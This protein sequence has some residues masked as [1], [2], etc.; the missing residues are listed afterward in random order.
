[1]IART[2]SFSLTPSSFLIA[3]V[4]AKDTVDQATARRGPTV[5]AN[6]LVSRYVVLQGAGSIASVRGRD[7]REP[8]VQQ[9]VT[10]RA[11]A[12]RQQHATLRQAIEATGAIIVGDMVHVANAFQVKVARSKLDSLTRLSMRSELIRIWQE[13]QQTILPM[14][15]LLQFVDLGSGTNNTSITPNNIGTINGHRLKYDPA[16]PTEGIFF[17]DSLGA[18]TKVT[19]VQKNKPG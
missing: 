19:A 17:V 18:A 16:D 9:L 11:R 12:L 7:L 13:K 3:L 10:A 15:A 6:E 1:M 8:A 14:P 2:T 4:S 5:A